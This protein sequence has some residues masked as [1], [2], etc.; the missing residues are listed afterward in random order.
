MELK[1]LRALLALVVVAA[2]L[3]VGSAAAPAAAVACDASSAGLWLS[4]ETVGSSAGVVTEAVAY[5]SPTPGL[6]PVDGTIC[7]PAATGRYPML[8]LNHG[9]FHALRPDDERL[10]AEWAAAGWFVVA[11]HYRVINVAP[12]G[13]DLCDGEVDD[14]LAMLA[15][16]GTHP[17]A[18]PTTVVLRGGSH[19]GCVTLRAVARGVPGLVAAATF[20]PLTDLA[21]T[22]AFSADPGVSA[23]I[24]RSTGDAVAA[25]AQRTPVVSDADVPLL[26]THGVDDRVIDVHDSCRFVAGHH[27]V[28]VHVGAAPSDCVDHWSPADPDWTGDRW[29]VTYD[30]VGHGRGVNW[31]TMSDDIDD[32]LRTKAL[33]DSR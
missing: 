32:F 29:F 6:P 31:R 23:Q 5:A 2:G 11:S 10:C 19:G 18:D 20:M 22:E 12:A 24:A 25:V 33:A 17:S 26:I 16:A 14:V 27:F 8:V 4:C 13:D 9:G 28:S 30:G 21:A 15:V 3:A 7:R 1:H